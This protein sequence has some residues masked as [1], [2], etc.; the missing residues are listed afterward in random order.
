LFDA[1]SLGASIPLFDS[2]I[3]IPS[4]PNDHQ[5]PTGTIDFSLGTLPSLIY[6][7]LMLTITLA[8]GRR[9]TKWKRF[10]RAPPP[11]VEPAT[12]KGKL[13]SDKDVPKRGKGVPTVFSV[14]HTT[15][16]M[17]VN[18]WLPFVAIGWF[19]SPFEYEHESTGDMSL[20]EPDG[21]SSAVGG[22]LE[23]KKAKVKAAMNRMWA[24]RGGSI[25]TEW[26]KR[27]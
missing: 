20:V 17:L 1:Q 16:G 10:H 6:G 22:I 19:N 3:P 26:G 11:T 18:G 8:D 24:A 5:P 9:A 23:Q 27:G 2:S 13:N 14:D 7:D 15:G 12:N 21:T 4:P 25:V